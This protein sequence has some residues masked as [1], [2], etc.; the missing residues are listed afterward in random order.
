MTH[1]ACESQLRPVVWSVTCG[2]IHTQET[3]WQL[4]VLLRIMPGLP[5]HLVQELN[6]HTA[7]FNWATRNLLHTQQH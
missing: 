7:Q 2:R 1:E 5:T 6:A 4:D 3:G